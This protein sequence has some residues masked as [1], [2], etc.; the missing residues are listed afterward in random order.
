MKSRFLAS[1][2]FIIYIL[3]AF[4]LNSCI[5]QDPKPDECKVVEVTVSEIYEGTSYDIVIRD[6]GTDKFYINR[7]LENG[8]TI[9]G[10]KKKILN[11]KVTLHLPEFIVGTSE[12]IA[13]LALENDIIYTE[14]ETPETALIK[15]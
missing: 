11:K 10:L 13:Q 12:H 3:L 14:F 8:L 5:I 7:G 4:L 9:E 2:A 1:S 15:Q 6:N